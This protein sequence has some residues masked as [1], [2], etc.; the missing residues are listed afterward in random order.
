M[1][2]PRTY[3]PESG[4]VGRG[5]WEG[6]R[7]LRGPRGVHPI[8]KPQKVTRTATKRTWRSTPSPALTRAPLEGLPGGQVPQMPASAAPNPGYGLQPKAGNFN[9]YTENLLVG[10]LVQP[11]TLQA[12]KMKSRERLGGAAVVRTT[13]V[14]SRLR[15]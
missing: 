1:P 10:Y 4:V 9:S 2:G 12:R 3:G 13:A 15:A 8:F 7:G 6:V 14:A 11:L 5:G